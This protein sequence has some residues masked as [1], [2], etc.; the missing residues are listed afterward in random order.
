MSQPELLKAVVGALDRAGIGYMVTGSLVSSLQGE[1]RS[2]HDIDVVVEL[3]NA[4]VARI[5]A[6]FP[7][8]RYYVSEAAAREAIR[9]SGTF[10]LIDTEEGD[11]IDFWL[12]TAAPFDVSRWSR[13][14]GEEVMGIRVMVSAPEDTVL[15]K[16]RWA[17]LSGGS[18][19]HFVDAL[20]VYEVQF[21][22]LDLDY[23]TT[24]TPRLG[25]EE[26]W[27]R[28]QAEARPL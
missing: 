22:V 23:L 16:L 12:S 24:W 10:N 15:A 4:D 11:T 26:L 14:R 7:P 6:A 28:L 19:K 17:K 27:Q 5:L 2:T 21:G 1:P 13:R 9:R 8:P 20:R 25:V 3:A 18:E